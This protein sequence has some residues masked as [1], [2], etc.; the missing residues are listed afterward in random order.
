MSTQNGKK[1]SK[2]S[3]RR[4]KNDIFLQKY[5]FRE[6]TARF[7]YRNQNPTFSPQR[8]CPLAWRS[9]VGGTKEFPPRRLRHGPINGTHERT[10]SRRKLFCRNRSRRN[11]A[12][13]GAAASS[14]AV[15]L[16]SQSA[17]LSD[18]QQVL[19]ATR[20]VHFFNFNIVK[21]KKKIRKK[22]WHLCLWT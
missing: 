10:E 6:N 9:L 7:V 1:H 15:S 8:S 11:V 12:T 5:S 21:K 19:H 2:W 17:H 18:V 20:S 3:L 22:T 13:G 4:K 16:R 14:Q